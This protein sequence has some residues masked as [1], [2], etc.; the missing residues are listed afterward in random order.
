MADG[1]IPPSAN[2]QDLLAKLRNFPTPL[3]PPVHVFD[4]DTTK[5]IAA[6]QLHPSLEAALHIL[7]HDLPSAHFLVRH[8]EAPP[9][10]EGMTLH[11]ILHCIEGDYD[12]ARAWYKDVASDEAGKELLEK[13]WG[14]HGKEGVLAFVDDV[15]KLDKKID[16]NKAELEQTSLNAIT[17]VVR[18]CEEKFGSDR[19]ED[20]LSA[21]TKSPEKNQEMQ[22]AM[23]IGEQ[24]HRKI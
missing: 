16:G 12:N 18:Q 8:M 5:Q 4:K 6:L 20:A 22:Q 21:W 11:G 19:W 14:K 17:V 10:V 3:L 15:E 9:A 2:Y 1:P 13:A 23:I 7:N 24:G